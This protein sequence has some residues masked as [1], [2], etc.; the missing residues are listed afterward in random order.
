MGARAGRRAG[1]KQGNAITQRP[2]YLS[3]PVHVVDKCYLGGQKIYTYSKIH[4]EQ[5]TTSLSASRRTFLVPHLWMHVAVKDDCGAPKV[6]VVVV[7]VTHSLWV[8]RTSRPVHISL[9]EVAGK[10][11]NRSLSANNNVYVYKIDCACLADAS[12]QADASSKL[13]RWGNTWYLEALLVFFHFLPLWPLS[14]CVTWQIKPTWPAT[15]MGKRGRGV[16]MH[17]NYVHN[18]PV[19]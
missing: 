16:S 2:T 10:G 5:S 8:R 12:I 7:L 18:D 4:R 9:K 3:L 13:R 19:H 17:F 11:L 1:A 14:K 6:S 15:E